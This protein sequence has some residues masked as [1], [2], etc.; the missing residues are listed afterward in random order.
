MKALNVP[1]VSRAK[2]AGFTIIE[3]VVVILLLGILTA[4]ALPR[5]M[6]VTDEAH[7]AVVDAVRGGLLTGNAL[8]RAQYV[9]EGENLGSA[10]AGFGAGTIF[11]DTNGTGYP[12]DAADGILD[13]EAEC[14]ALYNGMLQA[15]RPVAASAAFSAVAATLEANIEAAASATTD[16]VITGD[17]A[18]SPLTGCVMYY[19]GQFKSGNTT[20]SATIPSL[21]YTIATGDVTE[22]TL[23]LNN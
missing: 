2:Q 23:T 14:L 8:F 5:F 7:D 4:T 3:L 20:T 19:V 10:V 16:F 9:G 15:G 13:D 6:D 12:T 22:G 11:P 17:A 18:A 21:T 1:N